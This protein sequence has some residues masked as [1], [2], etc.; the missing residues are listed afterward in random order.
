MGT[1]S[2]AFSALIFCAT[3]I[4]SDNGEWRWVMVD[5]P[6]TAGDYRRHTEEYVALITSGIAHVMSYLMLR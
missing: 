3:D 4:Q 5:H 2:R 6:T 1:L